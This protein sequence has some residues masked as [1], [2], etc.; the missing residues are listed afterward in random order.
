[1]PETSKLGLPLVAA[2]QAQKHVTVNEGLTRL[3]ALVQLTLGSVGATV[4]PVTPV[5]GEAHA[6]GVGATDAWAGQDGQLGLFV[7]GGWVFLTPQ[8]GWQAS[9]AGTR[10]QY[11]GVDWLEGAGALS[12][13]GAGFAH[14][15]LELDHDVSAGGT[16]L[17]PNFL[18]EN[19]IVYGVT[20]RVVS[21]IGGATGMEVGVV[22]SSDRYGSGINTNAGA[23]MR[24]LTGSPLTYF[25]ATDLLLTALGGSF[26]GTGTVRL[27]VHFA[28]LT[29]PRA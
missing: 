18:P 20:G 16:S 15:S 7:N 12:S 26:D 5:E 9:S 29:L 13:N 17:V 23:W 19:S 27:A 1:M 14:R 11:D 24:G 25:A 3:D 21:V 2:A 8:T 22:G 28:E 4:P 10:V 6:I